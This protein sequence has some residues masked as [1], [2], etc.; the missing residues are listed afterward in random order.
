MGGRGPSVVV[1]STLFPNIAQPC[2][3]LFIRERM[4]RVG[5]H[6]P[7][8][9][10]APVPWFPC[11][12]LIR[13]WRPHFRPPVPFR[14]NQ[15]GID[16]IHPKFLSVP[17]LCKRLDGFF[18]ALGSFQ[19]MRSLK[20]SGRMDV[21][22]AHFG[23]PDGY[24]A[25]LLGRWFGKPVTITL[26]GT[27]PR[28]SRTPALK[29][30][31]A[32]ALVDANRVF[33][34][35]E[36]LRALAMQMGIAPAKVRVVGNGV[37]TARF[38]PLPRSQARAAL[39]LPDHVPVLVSVGGLT[40]R[41]GFHRVIELLPALS[42]AFPGLVFLIVGG[43]SAEGDWRAIL[44]Q[45]VKGLGLENMVRFLGVLAPDEL[46][47]PLSAADVFVLATRNEGWANVFLEA[48]ACGLPVVTTDVGGNREVV[49]RSELGIVV[50]F[51]DPEALRQA[52]D[53][54][55]ARSWD[56][57]ALRAYA[58]DN[59]WSKRVAELTG[60]FAA[61]AQVEDSGARNVELE[62]SSGG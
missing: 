23:Y 58:C 10:V 1:F 4:F 20:R 36:S 28:H 17:G 39:D 38:H 56:R 21:I 22:D 60:E 30:R 26:R 33:A 16:V 45:Q 35:S 24:A 29:F 53:S 52:I 32:R 8:T 3:G 19:V 41:K 49:C 57:G 14:E 5:Q 47:V 43:A 48:M 18:L 27:E 7:M 55:L 25:T 62:G 42:R 40:E 61:L 50:P 13:L 46:K 51:G 6:L 31:L 12:S 37:D 2:A 44:E 34:V 54:A 11:Q 59:E 9:V 15:S